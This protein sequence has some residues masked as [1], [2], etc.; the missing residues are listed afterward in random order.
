MPRKRTISDQ[1]LLDAALLIVRESGP[2]ALTFGS[3]ASRVALAGS[4]IVQRFGTKA[5]LL[6]AALS[7]A[8]DRLDEETAA[9]I[10]EVGDGPTGVVELLVRLSAQYSA[11]DFADQ[12]IIL[13]EDLRDPRLRARGE[14]WIATLEE[15]IE[16][17]LAGSVPAPD[18]LGRLVVA[19]WQG[20]VTV[21]SFLRHAPLKT[22]VAE[23]LT[24]VLERISGP[25]SGARAG[26]VAARQPSR[27][28]SR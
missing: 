1:D 11:E 3:L 2:D 12:L 15:A 6:H 26:S 4:T 13:R 23:A 5:A 9:S 24:D 16:E 17:R 18:G 28:R 8:W 20:A 27:R 7:R 21:W 10:R 25:A 19:H 22:A 14:A